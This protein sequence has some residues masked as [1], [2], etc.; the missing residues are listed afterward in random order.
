MNTAIGRR[1]TKLE[2]ELSPKKLPKIRLLWEP[3]P[4]ADADKWAAHNADL[5]DARRMGEQAIVIRGCYKPVREN[6]PGR[7]YVNS[8]WEADI[9]ILASQPSEHGNKNALQDMLKSLPGTVLGVV[10]NPRP[11]VHEIQ[12]M[13]SQ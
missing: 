6:R 7:R 13:R 10:A 12:I 2:D 4:G 5:E 3:V 1:I 8:Q 9:A 11:D